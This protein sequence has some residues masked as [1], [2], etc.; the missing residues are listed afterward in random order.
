[1][2]AVLAFLRSKITVCF[3]D[4]DFWILSFVLHGT[5]RGVELLL[6]QFAILQKYLDFMGVG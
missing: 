3:G 4:L 1:M 2:D 6:K 5:R